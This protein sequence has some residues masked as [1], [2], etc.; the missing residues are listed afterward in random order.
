M[1]ALGHQG[2]D[3]FNSGLA[4]SDRGLADIRDLG[5]G[6]DRIL[7]SGRSVLPDNTVSVL[8]RARGAVADRNTRDIMASGARLRQARLASG[9]RLSAEAAQEYM[10]EAEA[11]A[12]RAQGEANLAIDSQE[13]E[14]ELRETNTLRDRLAAAREAYL[15][16][17][18]QRM[19][20]GQAGQ[21]AALGLRNARNAAIAS[22]ISNMV[23]IGMTAGFGQQK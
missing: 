3:A 11:E 14:L 16:A 19:A 6:Y 22:T 23:G 5:D 18:M 7:R 8:K 9:G 13:A 1:R 17:G 21:I 10:T 4:I 15:G 12:N 2:K 20:L